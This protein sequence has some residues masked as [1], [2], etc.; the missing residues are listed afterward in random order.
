MWQCRYD[1]R[2]RKRGGRIDHLLSVKSVIAKP[3]N[4]FT[5]RRS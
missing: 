1:Y 4:L 3:R 2:F 5:M